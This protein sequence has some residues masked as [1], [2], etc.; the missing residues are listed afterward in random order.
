MP[1]VEVDP[2]Q[3]RAAAAVLDRLA[4]DVDALVAPVRGAAD[5]ALQ[6]AGELAR[7][8]SAGAGAFSWSWQAALRGAAG[9]VELTSATVTGAAARYDEVERSV[10]RPGPR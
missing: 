6:G 4:A 9:S 2:A 8:L 7:E 3:L 5:T 1:H 10:V